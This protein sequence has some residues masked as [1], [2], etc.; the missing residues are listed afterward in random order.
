MADDDIPTLDDVLVNL[1]YSAPDYWQQKFK[2]VLADIDQKA[3]IWELSLT[4]KATNAYAKV[5][6]TLSN[7]S[8]ASS[9]HTAASLVVAP[10]VGQAG[11]TLGQG[12]AVKALTAGTVAGL[13]TA[14]GLAGFVAFPVLAAWIA[15][16]K[17]A[18]T[19]RKTFKLWDL[20][21]ASKG[22]DGQMK[23]TCSK[24]DDIAYDL[25]ERFD[26][27]VAKIAV[28]AATVGVAALPI[29]LH[30]MSPSVAKEKR[31]L[32]V[33]LRLSAM[34]V[35]ILRNAVTKTRHGA[36][37]SPTNDDEKPILISGGCQKAQGLIAILF[38]EF[39]GKCRRTA[40]AILSI[41]GEKA[42]MEQI[43]V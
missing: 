27:K 1:R 30:A 22:G 20:V 28:S 14:V 35:S 4:N 6:G 7:A 31:K 43:P 15:A 29:L 34:P 11:L 32:A 13:G 38:G 10:H 40:A 2:T 19:A 18:W 12:G 39:D 16:G 21:P 26:A 36:R 41:D 8:N 17:V 24:C 37:P 5:Q 3:K 42:I 33:S 25:A 23:C 9:V